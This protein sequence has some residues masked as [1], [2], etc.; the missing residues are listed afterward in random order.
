MKINFW[1]QFLLDISL[2]RDTIALPPTACVQTG[3]RGGY[4]WHEKAAAQVES[5]GERALAHA[6]PSQWRPPTKAVINDVA[7][8]LREMAKSKEP[9]I[10]FQARREPLCDRS[11]A[12]KD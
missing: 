6:T 3:E 11:N 12:G 1:H 8:E 10:E 7:G 2:P 9:V 4:W 5:L